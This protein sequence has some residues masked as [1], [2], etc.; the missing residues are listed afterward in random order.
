MSGNRRGALIRIVQGW[1]NSATF[2]LENWPEDTQIHSAKISTL[3]GRYS[4]PLLKLLSM[5]GYV[6]KLIYERLGE[7]C[8]ESLVL[9]RDE[10][11][12]RGRK[13]LVFGTEGSMVPIT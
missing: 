13:S 9:Y 1:R 12:S 8:S 3:G 10:C 6:P 2:A 11:S 7:G 4:S 5:R